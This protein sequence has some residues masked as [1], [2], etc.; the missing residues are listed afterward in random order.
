M[1]ALHNALAAV[2]LLAFLYVLGCVGSF[3]AGHL[4]LLG[5]IARCGVA[6]AAL[7]GSFVVLGMIERKKEGEQ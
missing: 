7:Y 6:L 1:K 4:P 5:L 3:A 2:A